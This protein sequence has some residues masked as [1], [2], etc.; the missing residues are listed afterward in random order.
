MGKVNEPD[1]IVGIHALPTMRNTFSRAFVL[2]C[3]TLVFPTSCLATTFYAIPVAGLSYLRGAAAAVCDSVLFCVSCKYSKIKYTFE[4]K[5]LE[6]MSE[7]KE[8][9]QINS[10]VG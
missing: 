4:H 7:K 2:L 6:I 10:V 9:T 8:E 1:H 3:G 5:V